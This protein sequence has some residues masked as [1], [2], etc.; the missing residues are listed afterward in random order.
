MGEIKKRVLIVDD[1]KSST[2]SLIENNLA[3]YSKN[4]DVEY[5]DNAGDAIENIKYK[6]PD[7]IVL[8]SM[9]PYGNACNVLGGEHDPSGIETGYN[10]LLYLRQNCDGKENIEKTWV[11]FCS[12]RGNPQF[13]LKVEKAF[14]GFGEY[15]MK[16]YNPFELEEK[17][18]K[19]LNVPCKVPDFL[20]GNRDQK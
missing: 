10:L 9:L 5:V 13:K 8:D 6:I 14:G 1:D 20:L 18:C 19:V 16:P 17:I 4:F 3:E 2:E 15:I 11:F 7:I 12:A